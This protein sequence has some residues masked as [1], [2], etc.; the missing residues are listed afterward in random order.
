MLLK[1]GRSKN[2]L[3]PVVRGIDTTQSVDRQSN[4]ILDCKD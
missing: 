2:T 3:S 4:T 1:L